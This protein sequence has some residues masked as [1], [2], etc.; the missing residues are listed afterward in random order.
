MDPAR[1]LVALENLMQ[2]DLFD[3]I[4]Q[5][6]HD[7][8]PC[9]NYLVY[10]ADEVDPE[11]V[12]LENLMKA[13]LF[14][15]TSLG[16]LN[17]LPFQYSPL[18]GGGII[19]LLILQRGARSDPLRG[20]LIHV[21]VSKAKYEALSYAWGNIATP[22]NIE[23]DGRELPLTQSLS[24]AL[25]RL[26]SLRK[27][28]VLWADGI[29]INQD[30]N[31]EK[32][33]QIALMPKI[34]SSAIKVLV[35]LGEEE[36]Q[37]EQIPDLMQ[38]IQTS[39]PYDTRNVMF[40][41]PGPVQTYL[42]RVEVVRNFFSRLWFHRLWVGQE[43]V[44]ASNVCFIC[45]EWEATEDC[46]SKL[47][48]E[49]A[50]SVSTPSLE[51]LPGDKISLAGVSGL[52]TIMGIKVERSLMS[53]NSSIMKQT[54][55]GYSLM[56]ASTVSKMSI[57]YGTDWQVA[58]QSLSERVRD[59]GDHSIQA[60]TY[61][62]GL[63]RTFHTRESTNQRDRFYSLLGLAKDVT[64]ND[65][66]FNYDEPVIETKR[67][68][69][70]MLVKKG[71]GMELMY[72]APRLRPNVYH[73]PQ[74]CLDEE[75]APL[76][77]W[78][79]EWTQP[80]PILSNRHASL[81]D[82]PKRLAA[83]SYVSLIDGEPDVLKVPGFFLDMCEKFISTSITES[84]PFELYNTKGPL[85]RFLKEVDDLMSGEPYLTGEPWS[86]VQWRTLIG[87]GAMGSESP[88]TEFEGQYQKAKEFFN[89]AQFNTP[90]STLQSL[91]D[92]YQVKNSNLWLRCVHTR[93]FENKPARTLKGYVGIVPKATYQTDRIFVLKGAAMPFVLRPIVRAPGHYH[94]IG[95]CY[96][97]G[98]ATGEEFKGE[99]R[100][101]DV[102]IY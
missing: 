41:P 60:D 77:S 20:S 24:N 30:N 54:L 19:R 62:I 12:E 48:L 63:L 75:E 11:L 16:G 5:D 39:D 72:A 84:G 73:A 91:V 33:A 85:C 38:T 68:F 88:P 31:L 59:F 86:E 92:L 69:C 37:S 42:D 10:G 57:K 80:P 49:I 90:Q 28:R 32:G 55:A 64:I 65:F 61:I 98:I 40:T 56:D 17:A 99:D 27:D 76:P 1:E 95:V 74:S 94:F 52:A 23:L 3:N 70:R 81:M 6:K 29:C 101:V 2:A 71:Q 7:A 51:M 83:P 67:R 78:V 26:R 79:P 44:L 14:G 8:S 66:P 45:G 35:Y 36:N 97:H 53:Q 96:I 82:L 87:N 50:T 15:G 46:L 13:E 25:V 100:E 4:S 93:M 58:M 43:V 89:E 9:L 102:L 21:P 18:N 22:C 47:A 34:Y